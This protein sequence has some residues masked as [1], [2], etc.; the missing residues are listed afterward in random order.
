MNGRS[1]AGILPT[2]QIFVEGWAD[3]DSKAVLLAALLVHDPRY[4]LI[5][6][7]LPGH[8]ILG[9]EGIPRP[10]QKFV[11]FQGQRYILVLPG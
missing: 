6:I 7:R 9:I 11:D 3:C 1:I 4:R 8:I 2:P 10:F 5:F